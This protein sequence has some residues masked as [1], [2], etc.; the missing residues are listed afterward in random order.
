MNFTWSPES[1]WTICWA[2]AFVKENPRFGVTNC[3]CWSSKL[4]PLNNFIS[5]LSM[6]GTRSNFILDPFVDEFFYKILKLEKIVQKNSEILKINLCPF[7]P[8]QSI[9]VHFV[10]HIQF[11]R[12]NQ[13]SYVYFIIFSQ[14]MSILSYSIFSQ[15]MFILSFMF[16][17]IV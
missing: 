4:R 13:Y 17:F 3:C 6:L 8:I 14:F 15:F 5:E 11:H 10:S 7:C 2:K 16:N 1:I 12:S 9:C